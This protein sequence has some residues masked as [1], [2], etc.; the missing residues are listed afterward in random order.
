M[1]NAMARKRQRKLVNADFISFSCDESGWER[2]H[3]EKQDGGGSDDSSAF[4]PH[5]CAG[6]HRERVGQGNLFASMC[7][8]EQ[9]AGGKNGNNGHSYPM[10]WNWRGRE[11]LKQPGEQT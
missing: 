1:I 2:R 4:R 5:L 6:A 11:N 7:P 9:N 8:S 3:V 10:P